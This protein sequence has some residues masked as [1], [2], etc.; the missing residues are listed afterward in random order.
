MNV[1]EGNQKMTVSGLPLNLSMRCGHL[2]MQPDFVIASTETTSIFPSFPPCCPLMN[3]HVYY[4]L[5][6][7]FCQECDIFSSVFAA[8][9]TAS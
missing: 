6:I 7:F 8:Q 9:R 5:V 4:S 1:D 2:S 3:L